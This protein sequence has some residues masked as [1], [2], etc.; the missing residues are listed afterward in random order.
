MPDSATLTFRPMFLEDLG[1]SSSLS[2]TTTTILGLGPGITVTPIVA[3]A[4]DAA[5]TNA[6]LAGGDVYLSD[7]TV[8]WRLHCVGGG[9]GGGGGGGNTTMLT[10]SATISVGTLL[11]GVPVAL[12]T[13]I[14]IAG[15]I[16]GDFCS[17]G[18]IPA[19]PTGVWAVGKISSA[20]TAVIELMNM[21]GAPLVIGNV[22]F[23]AAVFHG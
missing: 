17:V 15:A 3:A 23:N 20:N 10:G 18:T 2:Q 1:T 6:G 7:G 4:S 9:G 5:A 13:N 11:D 14:T 12:G 22:V 16:I 19:L 21:T 8:P